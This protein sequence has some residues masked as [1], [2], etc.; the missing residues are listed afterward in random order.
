MIYDINGKN[1]KTLTLNGSREI[2]IQ[3]LPAGIYTLRVSDEGKLVSKR[4][5]KK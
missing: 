2:N 4:F 5:I 3:D 1:V